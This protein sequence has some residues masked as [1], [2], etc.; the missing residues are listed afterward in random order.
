MTVQWPAGWQQD[1]IDAVTPLLGSDVRI[2]VWFGPTH[3][4][5]GSLLAGYAYLEDDVPMIIHDHTGRPDVY[6]WKLYGG[7]ILRVYQLRPRRRKLIL[8]A[9]PHWVPRGG[10][11]GSHT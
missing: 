10:E 4:V 6:P 7:H 5:D 9:D 2:E 3:S 11:K 8:F 1:A